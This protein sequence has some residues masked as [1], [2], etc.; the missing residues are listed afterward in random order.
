MMI[1]NLRNGP[2]RIPGTVV[3]QNC[4]M[5]YLIRVRD[6]QVWRQHIDHLRYKGDIQRELCTTE[7][8]KMNLLIP[9]YLIMILLM[10]S[11]MFQQKG[12]MQTPLTLLLGVI[13]KEHTIPQIIDLSRLCLTEGFVICSDAL[14]LFL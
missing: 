9:Q 11:L 8:A 7:H 6:N 5:T 10:K 2:H 1:R 14:R 3:K 12:P 13:H 4:P